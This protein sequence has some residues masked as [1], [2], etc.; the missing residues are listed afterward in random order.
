M[1]HWLENV[2][3]SYKPS[4]CLFIVHPPGALGCEQHL[5]LVIWGSLS[6]KM[7]ALHLQKHLTETNTANNKEKQSFGEEVINSVWDITGTAPL[8]F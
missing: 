5:V 2:F 7:S 8:T 6:P 3:V 4:L 1:P